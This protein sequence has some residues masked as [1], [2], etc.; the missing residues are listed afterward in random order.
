MA[1]TAA[2]PFLPRVEGP[3]EWR[4]SMTMVESAERD[5]EGGGDRND[6]RPSMTGTARIGGGLQGVAAVHQTDGNQSRLAVGLISHAR[7]VQE[8]IPNELLRSEGA[9]WQSH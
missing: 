7:L 6:A 1:A 5:A 4:P 2:T 9:A 8:A 3:T